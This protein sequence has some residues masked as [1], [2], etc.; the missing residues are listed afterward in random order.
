[1][2][3]V[4]FNR[5]TSVILHILQKVFSLISGVPLLTRQQFLPVARAYGE[6]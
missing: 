3:V 6:P 4:F 1:M 2:K 5:H